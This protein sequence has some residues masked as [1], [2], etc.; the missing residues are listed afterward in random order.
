LAPHIEVKCQAVVG[1]HF[2]EMTFGTHWETVSDTSH[3]TGD[4]DS[5]NARQA[6]RLLVN[7]PEDYREVADKKGGVCHPVSAGGSGGP[8]FKPIDRG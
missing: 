7:H 3:K 8:L 6:H 1:D 4:V 2:S 5:D